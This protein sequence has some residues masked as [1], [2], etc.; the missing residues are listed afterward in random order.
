[1]LKNVI[2]FQFQ[3]NAALEDIIDIQNPQE[4]EL[5]TTTVEQ[6]RENISYPTFV[7]YFVTFVCQ[8]Y[9]DNCPTYHKFNIQFYS[10]Q[11]VLMIEMD[12]WS[13]L[14]RT[15]I[16]QKFDLIDDII[17]KFNKEKKEAAYEMFKS[18][19]FG[20]VV[21]KKYKDTPCKIIHHLILRL[22]STSTKR[23]LRFLLNGKEV[24]FGLPEFAM[25]TGL[26][27]EPIPNIDLKAL[28]KNYS[29]KDRFFEKMKNIR[30]DILKSVWTNLKIAT[31]EE[32]V[33]L[34]NLCLLEL[35]FLA[36]TEN[37]CITADHVLIASNLE[38]FNNYP[39]G[40]VIFEQTAESVILANKNA[41]N[42]PTGYVVNGCA[43]ALL[44]FAF[45][46]IP[47]LTEKQ[48]ALRADH[49]LPQRLVNWVYQGNPRFKSLDSD[50]FADKQVIHS[51]PT[52]TYVYVDK[53]FTQI[54]T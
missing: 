35:F 14:Q 15:N 29:L 46:I 27:C 28:T 11:P 22:S 25:I 7:H 12:D 3:T 16:T 17:E 8:F 51:I 48:Y 21:H 18:G 13:P 6:V 40:R 41:A 1:M 49:Q 38:V 54:V 5:A 34:A 43:Y 9:S 10:Q 36:K 4:I 20:Y 47:K 31:D 19:I 52:P 37:L 33:Q 42:K 44:A 53:N 26:N 24:K 32:W 30:G 50:V 39:W 23:E 2:S 45:E